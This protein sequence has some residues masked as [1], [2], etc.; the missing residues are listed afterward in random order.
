VLY[1]LPNGNFI[2]PS[3]VIRIRLMER[4]HV[5][6][7]GTFPPRVR[8]DMTCEPMEMV[9]FESN[10]DARVFCDNLVELSNMAKLVA[11][12]RPLKWRPKS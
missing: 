2:E 12:K 8:I 6:R 4:E 5:K 9:L 1:Q 7:A 3:E 10:E 11:A